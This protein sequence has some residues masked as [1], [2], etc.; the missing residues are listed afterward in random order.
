[1]TEQHTPKN[2]TREI[3][4]LMRDKEVHPADAMASLAMALIQVALYLGVTKEALQYGVGVSY[5]VLNDDSDDEE[6][7]SWH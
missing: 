6:K 5:D 2:V 7:H 1:M 3:H 4:E